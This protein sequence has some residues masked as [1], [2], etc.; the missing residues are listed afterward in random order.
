M[1]NQVAE[2]YWKSQN[3]S[4]SVRACQIRAKA[5]ALTQLMIDDNETETSPRLIFYELENEPL[6][7][8]EKR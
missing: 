8:A 5:D 3:R 4:Q 7:T 1:M 2:T 6:P